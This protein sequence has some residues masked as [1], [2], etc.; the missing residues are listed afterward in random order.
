MKFAHAPHLQ[1]QA[2]IDLFQRTAALLGDPPRSYAEAGYALARRGVI[3]EEAKLYKSVVGFAGTRLLKRGDRRGGG[4]FKT[5]AISA[6]GRAG[7]ESR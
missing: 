5:A 6:C 3:T 4:D 2:L 7:G 1:A